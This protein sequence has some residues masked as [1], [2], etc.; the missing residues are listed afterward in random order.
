MTPSSRTFSRFF[1]ALA[2]IFAFVGIERAQGI[3]Y[4]KPTELPNP[5]RLVEGWPT[6]PKSMNGGQWGEVIA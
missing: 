2:A 6:L 4:P 5:Y 1:V 3:H